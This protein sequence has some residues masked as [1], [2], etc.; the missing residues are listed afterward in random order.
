MTG[1]RH[2][3]GV[4]IQRTGLLPELAAGP[5]AG[6][7]AEVVEGAGE[8]RKKEEEGAGRRHRGRGEQS[9]S[10]S[11]GGGGSGAGAR[12]SSTQ[13]TCSKA[14]STQFTCTA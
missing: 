14:S 11:A 8:K 9:G 7:F 1:V 13:F 4:S 12:D 5:Q 6:E 10:S 3:D 2:D